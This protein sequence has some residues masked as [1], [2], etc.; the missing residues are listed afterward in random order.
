M[1]TM[2]Q[3]TTEVTAFASWQQFAEAMDNGYVPTL[4]TD[5]SDNSR[6]SREWN[7]KVEQLADRLAAMGYR[8]HR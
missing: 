6:A 3:L 1:M 8:I 2:N 4:A 7:S 5:D